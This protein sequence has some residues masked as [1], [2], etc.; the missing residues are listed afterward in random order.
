[1]TQSPPSFKQLGANQAY[2]V[3]PTVLT[4]KVKGKATT[5][6]GIFTFALAKDA[7]SWHIAAWAWTTL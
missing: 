3:V 5:E 2:A 7:S 4:Y 6:K 1:M